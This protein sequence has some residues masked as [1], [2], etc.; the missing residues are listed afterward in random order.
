MNYYW[1]RYKQCWTE[2]HA[3]FSGSAYTFTHFSLWQDV[4]APHKSS[5]HDDVI[6]WKHSPRY[7]PF[8]RGIH[9][10]PVNSPHEGQWRG[11]LMFSL[12][13]VWI[14][15]WVNNREAGDLRRYRGHYDVTVMNI[16]LM[17]SIRVL[18][19]RF[20][21][22]H[23]SLRC[24]LCQINNRFNDEK[25]PFDQHAIISVNITLVYW[26]ILG[27]LDREE[28]QWLNIIMCTLYITPLYDTTFNQQNRESVKLSNNEKHPIYHSH[29]IC[30]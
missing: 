28:I 27:L 30:R 6:K 24:R 11:A 13:F 5:E 26:R 4:A 19:S 21:T 14:N 20:W 17:Q 25:A 8:V 9:R 29:G 10:F 3:L 15:D 22:L 2:L 1:K 12:I 16:C 23:C 7:W 18:I